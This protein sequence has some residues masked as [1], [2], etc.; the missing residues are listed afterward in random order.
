MWKTV[1]LHPR[2][3]RMTVTMF[4]KKRYISVLRHLLQ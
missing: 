3:V 1:Q 2:T 4:Y